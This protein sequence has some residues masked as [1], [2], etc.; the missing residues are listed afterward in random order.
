ML[1]A[2]MEIKDNIT[3]IEETYKTNNHLRKAKD[4]MKQI[5]DLTRVKYENGLLEFVELARAEQNLLDAENN[6]IEN[7]AQILQ[8]IT[9][10]YKSIGGGYSIKN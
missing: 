1:T 8:N 5:L 2:I 4:K 7:N 10:F 9:S 6:L 3:F